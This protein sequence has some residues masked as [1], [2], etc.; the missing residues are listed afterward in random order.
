MAKLR[1][2]FVDD[3]P[4]FQFVFQ[5]WAAQLFNVTVADSVKAALKRLEAEGTQ[6]YHA[7]VSD[8]NMPE[9][10]GIELLRAVR[11]QDP[12]KPFFVVSANPGECTAEV[13][14]A[15][16]RACICKST[17]TRQICELIQEVAAAS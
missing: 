6:A 3:D 7:I 15:G 5:L 2:L 10:N 4:V 8:Y 11:E 1:I 17:P 13:K 14:A 12:G 16:A 9:A